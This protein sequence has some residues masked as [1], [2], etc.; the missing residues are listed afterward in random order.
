[1][2]GYTTSDISKFVHRASLG[3]LIPNS[4]AMAAYVMP[5]VFILLTATSG[6]LNVFFLATFFTSEGLA[7]VSLLAV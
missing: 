5:P 3:A 4:L 2:D 1:L 7:A 6:I